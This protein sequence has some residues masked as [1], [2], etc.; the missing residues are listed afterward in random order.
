MN[1][2]SPLANHL[3]QSTVFAAAAALLSLA[4]RQNRAEIR[5]RLWL[6]ASL[7][8]LVPLAPLI[9]LASRIEWSTA[10]ALSSPVSAALGQVSAPF[11]PPIAAAA[12][13]APS[14]DTGSWLPWF[15][16]AVWACGTGA[17]FV[18]WWSRSR[19]VRLAVQTA[20]PFGISAPVKVL[21]TRAR[22]EPGIFG[23]F[24]PILLLPEGI[25]ACLTPAQLRA[26]LA[27]EF[28]HVRRRDNLWTA[29]HMLAE[30]LFWFH[31]L[32]WWIGAQ[33]VDERERACDQDVLRLGNDAE[34]YASG[35]LHVCRHYL[36]S[37]LPCASG[38]TG[39]DLE[40]RI[41]AILS[42]RTLRR[43]TAARKALLGAA[44][45]SAVAVPIALGLL[46]AQT[47][48]PLRFEVASIKPA[49]ETGR[50]YLEVMP[51]GGLR[52]GA[53]T[54]QGLVAMAYDVRPEQVSGG[55]K[56]AA[57]DAYSLLAKPERVHPDDVQRTGAPGQASWDR[58]RERLRTLLAERF[59]VAI[60]KDGKEASGYQLVTAKSGTK[61]T[62]TT[63]LQPAGTVR[64]HGTINGRSG[65]MHMLATVLTQYVG[66]PV[67]DRTGLNGNYDY[68]LEYADNPGPDA[69]AVEAP[70]ASIYT[71]LQEQLGLKLEPARVTL[72]TIVI[73]K[74]ERP[75]AN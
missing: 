10:P 29:V 71:A 30:A 47:R 60:R 66:R 7:K 13:T 64:S 6:A 34:V 33:L 59:Q 2:L 21:S 45:A 39:A 31:P 41:E 18:R 40:R 20:S 17:M 49:K 14:N 67:V 53:I 58:L 62:P 61:L 25:E 38:V 65:T 73:E 55:P 56:W 22:L 43:L 57:T 26:I 51:G 4:L 37:P 36:E 44:G 72:D 27:H 52:L 50:G 35:I 46:Q 3:W 28:C 69:A 5:Y 68:K 11:A 19:V 12:T 15:L 23:V 70:G 42:G 54:V 74:V 8:F 32:V 9:S 24:R 75:S 48:P 16:L 63:N 1:A